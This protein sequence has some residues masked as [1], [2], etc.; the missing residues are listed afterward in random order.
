MAPSRNPPPFSLFD[1]AVVRALAGAQFSPVR[2]LGEGGS[3][4]VY[5]VQ[6]HFES[7]RIALKVLR[8]ELAPSAQERK[9]FLAEAARMGRLDA[10]GLVRLIESGELSDG[11]PYLAMPLLDGETLSRRLRRGPL[12]PPEALRYF[13]VLAKAVQ[14][15]HDA[16]MVHR[17]IKP[18]NILVVDDSPVL[19]DFGIAR[20]IDDATTTTTMEGRVRGTP[21][22]M[23]PERVLGEAASVRSDVYEL[24]VVY[25][26]MLVGRLP[27]GDENRV[28]ER[29]NPK[30][31]RDVGVDVPTA[32]S[33]A[34]LSALSTRPEVRPASARE[35]EDAVFAANG[36]APL[37]SRRT[38]DFD[39]RS[40]ARIALSVP[41][42]APPST[43]DA[44]PVRVT[45]APV[46]ARSR[47]R[48]AWLVALLSLA[49][50][51]GG[52][53]AR[54]SM[55]A[56]PSQV[57]AVSK[58]VVTSAPNVV[59]P[60]PPSAAS[61]LSTVPVAAA[62]PPVVSFPRRERPLGVVSAERRAAPSATTPGILPV[63]SSDPSRYFEDRK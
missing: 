38:L 39:A 58:A 8:T 54:R 51:V 55:V 12:S 7:T 26:M 19:L 56:G 52:L 45:L 61:A 41:P 20:D 53:F 15:L 57:P 43:D 59:E 36:R 62:P 47:V 44:R 37:S 30:G 23:A 27:W 50:L 29:L 10:P 40:S 48:P 34:L 33:R 28:A 42:S 13:S 63:P 14:A 5:E 22:Y 60:S 16:G 18:E 11:R 21:A 6:R 9:R 31:P 25:Y 3:G 1:D 35:F 24:A 32:L 49:A 17:D 46:R 4:I 2:V